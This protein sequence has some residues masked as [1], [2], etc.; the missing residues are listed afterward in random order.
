MFHKIMEFKLNDADT[1]YNNGSTWIILT[2]K[3]QWV[4]ELTKDGTL[5]YNFYFFQSILTGLMGFE[6]TVKNQKYITEWVENFIRNGMKQTQNPNTR[7]MAGVYGVKHTDACQIGTSTSIEDAIQN[8]VKQTQ[9]G[10][11]QRKNPIEDAIQNGVKETFLVEG[12][13]NR[14]VEDTIQNGVKRILPESIPDSFGI[15]DAIQNGVKETYH[16]IRQRISEIE[17]TIQNGVTNTQPNLLMSELTIEETI[18]NGIKETNPHFL[19]ILNPMNF[20]P[21]TK[22]MKRMNEVNIVLEK[23]IKETKYCELHSLMRADH[24]IRDGIKETWGYEKQ[25][26]IR[27]TEVINEGIKETNWRKVD[28][29]P[30]YLDNIIR[31]NNCN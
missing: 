12:T 10:T 20:E 28:N 25:P 15:N 11:N 23:G 3:K 16:G 31:A 21:V 9:W 4:I 17:D 14:I 18:Q 26:Q 30:T 2:D 29:H 19:E 22:E 7:V 1:Y 27:V 6:D 24:I 8:G 5:W 13:R